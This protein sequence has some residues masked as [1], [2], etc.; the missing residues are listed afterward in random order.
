MKKFR[1]CVELEVEIEA[2]DIDDA[3]I[4]ISD[5]FGKGELDDVVNIKKSDSH[6]M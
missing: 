3:Q 2:F 5:Y 4:L 6:P 1:F